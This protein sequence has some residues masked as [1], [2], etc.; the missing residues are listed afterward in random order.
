MGFETVPG[1]DVTYGLIAFDADGAERPEESGLMS[2]ALV[3]RAV[4]TS[5]TDIFFFC[6]GWK[7]D[8]PAAKDQYG[9]WIGAFMRSD[10]RAA[11][12]SRLPGFQPLLIGLHWP[13]Q[14][15]GDEELGG[16]AFAAAGGAEA[17][18][19]AYLQR[20]GD[21]PDIRGPLEVIFE[22]ARRNAAPETL[23]PKVRQAYLD[24][25]AALG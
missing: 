1:S 21:G 23:P 6:H 14:P 8:I 12:A 16:G 3:E 9:K 20:L 15:W 17:L 7:G 25:N 24:L 4:S 13:S 11:A 5:V 10:D 22:E 19:A 2:R 18:F